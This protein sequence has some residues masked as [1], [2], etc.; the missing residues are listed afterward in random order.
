MRKPLGKSQLSDF[1]QDTLPVFL[2]TVKFIKNKESVRNF[3]SQEQPKKPLL[4]NVMENH[5]WDTEWK[6]HIE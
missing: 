4:L 5:G 2:K 1:L 6:K 3:N